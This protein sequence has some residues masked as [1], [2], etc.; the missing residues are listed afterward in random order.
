M[1]R[2]EI[3]RGGRACRGV[4]VVVQDITG[5]CMEKRAAEIMR[6]GATQTM[7]QYQPSF[8]FSRQDCWFGVC[9]ML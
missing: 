3:M 2:A 7:K 4:D 6:D 8:F 9:L 5:L 1:S